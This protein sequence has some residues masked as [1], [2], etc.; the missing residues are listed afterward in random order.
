MAFN[1]SK[2]EGGEYS[3]VAGSTVINFQVSNMP[4]YTYVYP[5]INKQS[6]TAYTRPETGFFGEQIVTDGL[7]MAT[8]QIVIPSDTTLNFPIGVLEVQFGDSSISFESSKIYATTTFLV[9]EDIQL[10]TL[11]ANDRLLRSADASITDTNPD[12]SDW[13]TKKSYVEPLAQVFFID[14]LVYPNGVF[15]TSVDLYFYGKD[16]AKTVSVEIRNVVGGTPSTTSVYSESYVVKTPTNVN[17]PTTPSSG[18]DL[19]KNT[20]FVFKKPIYLLPNQEYALCVITESANY[21]L[22]NGTFGASIYNSTNNVLS[23]QNVRRLF[24]TADYSNPDLDTDICFKLNVAKF[25]T[26]EVTFNIISNS[27]TITDYYNRFKFIPVVKNFTGVSDV[28]YAIFTKKDGAFPVTP[29]SVSPNYTVVLDTNR[30]ANAAG[31]V[32]VQTTFTNQNAYV[33]PILDLQGTNLVVFNDNPLS[34]SSASTTPT[35]STYITK[36]YKVEDGKE[37]T[38]ISVE[39]G[40][41]KPADT[42]I[43]VYCKLLGLGDDDIE[44]NEWIALPRKKDPTLVNTTDLKTFVKDIYQK[45]SSLTYTAGTVTYSK[46]KE[47]KIR[48]DFVSTNSALTPSINKMI[49]RTV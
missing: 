22:Y 30:T 26:G 10:V 34:S 42:N 16:S 39:V 25:A 13:Q 19:T 41:N 1:T 12:V 9:G 37:F 17:V 31:D 11:Q 7:G 20:N 32:K 38:G 35:E 40:V 28:N 4:A 21:K 36:V 47:F 27:T 43:Y 49:V 44:D 24:K 23:N 33:S 48:I 29:T 3:T 5:Y 15:A 45:L 14:P 18:L 46:F 8:G 6:I 2:S